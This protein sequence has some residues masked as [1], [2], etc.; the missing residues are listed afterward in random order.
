[1]IK[2][3]PFHFVQDFIIQP[4]Q[5]SDKRSLLALPTFNSQINDLSD[6]AVMD[7]VLFVKIVKYR[8]H[9]T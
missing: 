6:Q 4:C 3:P 5:K 8:H 1:M 9:H 7:Q 2:Q